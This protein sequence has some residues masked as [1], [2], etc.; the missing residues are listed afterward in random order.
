MP[1][2]VWWDSDEKR[3]APSNKWGGVRWSLT[4]C[5][6]G[7]SS[8]NRPE[9]VA[10]TRQP[11][12]G[13][14]CTAVLRPCLQILCKLSA[15]P[16]QPSRCCSRNSSHSAVR[17]PAIGSVTPPEGRVPSRRAAWHGRNRHGWRGSAVCRR[18]GHRPPIRFHAPVRPPACHLQGINDQIGRHRRRQGPPH[19]SAR[20]EGKKHRQVESAFA[21]RHVGAVAD[22]GAVRHGQQH[23][24]GDEP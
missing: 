10:G 19:Q 24:A 5:R 4:M 3:K 9:T 22:V 17:S 7:G 12:T 16:G 20:R 2:C 13:N 8:A 11:A 6:Q 14:Q 1:F 18:D 15:R 21:A 23:G